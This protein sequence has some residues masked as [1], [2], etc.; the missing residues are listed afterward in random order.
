[1]GNQASTKESCIPY[2]DALWFCYSKYIQ[3]NPATTCKHHLWNQRAWMHL[4]MIP[5]T[6]SHSRLI[7]CLAVIGEP[8]AQD[9][10]LPW[11]V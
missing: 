8:A 4:I 2:F 9:C 7:R 11:L 3:Y 1:M 5:S 6:P 10:M